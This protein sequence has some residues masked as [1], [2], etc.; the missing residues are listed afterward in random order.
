[1][2]DGPGETG[3]REPGE[4]PG[5]EGENLWAHSWACGRRGGVMADSQV[6]GLGSAMVPLREWGP[7]SGAVELEARCLGH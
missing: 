7:G 3:S 1:M 4:G 2:L 5:G 6:S